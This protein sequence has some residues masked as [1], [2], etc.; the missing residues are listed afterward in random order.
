MKSLLASLGKQF[1]YLGI[2]LNIFNRRRAAGGG[3]SEDIV[4]D[5]GEAIVSDSGE[6][7]VS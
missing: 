3:S 7:I 2:G 1:G 4:T 5:S 6:Q